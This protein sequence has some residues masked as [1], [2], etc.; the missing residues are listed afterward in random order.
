LSAPASNAQK[1]QPAAHTTTTIAKIIRDVGIG[2]GLV[3]AMSKANAIRKASAAKKYQSGIAGPFGGV[4]M[5]DGANV[6]FGAGE[7]PVINVRTP[8]AIWILPPVFSVSLCGFCSDNKLP[9]P[10]PMVGLDIAKIM[11]GFSPKDNFKSVFKRILSV[12]RAA[13]LHLSSAR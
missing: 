10:R 1:P 6:F 5:G 9:R 8:G 13:P 2:F 11:P 7:W 3:K 12:A 4:A